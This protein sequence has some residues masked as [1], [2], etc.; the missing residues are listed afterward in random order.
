M[1]SA[2]FRKASPRKPATYHAV[3]EPVSGGRI[4]AL[5]VRLGVRIL[6]TRVRAR[7]RGTVQKRQWLVIVCQRQRVPE[8]QIERF[9]NQNLIHGN[10][11][12]IHLV[13]HIREVIGS[14]ELGCGRDRRICG[15]AR[16][17]ELSVVLR[18][19]A[20]ENVL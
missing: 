9:R 2:A 14:S 19:L 20:S 10:H 15:S 7:K 16:V 3:I 8:F 11:E 4:K 17:D 6:S 1:H 18:Q 12:D 5:I 13:L